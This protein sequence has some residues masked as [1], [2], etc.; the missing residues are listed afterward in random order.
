MFIVG[1]SSGD[2]TGE[3]V[4]KSR[5][6]E[7]GSGLGGGICRPALGRWRGQMYRTV[8]THLHST[9]SSE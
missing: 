3:V 2:S 1:W 4:E 9:C 5:R 6:E 8:N 7:P